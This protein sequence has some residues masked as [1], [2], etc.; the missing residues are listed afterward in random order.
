VPFRT[1]GIIGQFGVL[2]LRSGL[3]YSA[4]GCL[5]GKS[6]AFARNA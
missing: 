2:R 6:A 4:I 5:D 3:S 1:L